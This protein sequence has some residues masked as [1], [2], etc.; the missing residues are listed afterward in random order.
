MR[1]FTDRV[2]KEEGWVPPVVGVL[3]HC[4]LHPPACTLFL[5][6]SVPSCFGFN[7]YFDGVRA[8]FGTL[9]QCEAR[10][11]GN[12]HSLFLSDLISFL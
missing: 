2:D 10:V 12:I 11:R 7:K 3:L 4:L 1:T 8:G 5:N 9:C 6:S